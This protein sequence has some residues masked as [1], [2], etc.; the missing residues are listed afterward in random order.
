MARFYLVKIR[1]NRLLW[2]PR[3]F[4]P[5]DSFFSGT[6]E[7]TVGLIVNHRTKRRSRTSK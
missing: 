7:W 6:G 4:I 2:T 1:G 5:E 3:D